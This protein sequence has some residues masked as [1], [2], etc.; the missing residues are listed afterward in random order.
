M[1]DLQ[2]TSIA[3]I[4]R[5]QHES[6]AYVASPN[7]PV[8]RFSWLRDGSFIGYAMLRE[9]EHDSCSRFLTW[10]DGTVSSQKQRVERVV[11]ARRSGKPLEPQEFLPA[12]YNLD[13]SLS[14]DSWP[15][16][17]IDGY[18]T[19]LWLLAKYVRQTGEE[20]LL[21]RFHESIRLTLDYLE[22]VW[23]LPG[24]DCWE[25][26]GDFLHPSTLACVYGGINSI[27]GLLGEKHLTTLTS[28]IR[29]MILGFTVDGRFRK[30]NECGDVDSSLLWLSLPFEVVPL[31]DE[32]MRR[33]VRA[34]EEELYERGGVKRYRSDT[35]YGGG[36]WILLACWLGWYHLRAGNRQKAEMVLRWVESQ[37]DA[38][39]NLPEQ[40][41]GNT[42]DDGYR[43]QWEQRWGEIARPLLW[44]HAMYLVLRRELAEG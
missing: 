13:G 2:S 15:N 11:A 12:R 39:G 1:K 35:Y 3:L 32:R 9:G 6:G 43:S 24:F 7:F 18:G 38:E 33:T 30:N 40:V 29:E 4:K 42:T 34:I 31:H 10:V 27:N 36:L 17:Q 26:F 28:A 21:H 25:E 16:F 22:A 41:P 8:Y 23:N 44:S 37:A 20:T 14:A 5:H 19:W